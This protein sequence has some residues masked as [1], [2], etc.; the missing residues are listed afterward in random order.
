MFAFEYRTFFNF[1]MKM[2]Y[3][4]GDRNLQNRILDTA[5]FIRLYTKEEGC[6]IL[7]NIVYFSKKTVEEGN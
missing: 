6:C 5:D 4:K 2:T 1:E 3:Y 7:E